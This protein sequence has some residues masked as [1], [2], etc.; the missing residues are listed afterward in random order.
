MGL[1][2]FHSCKE[3]GALATTNLSAFGVAA[4]EPSDGAPPRHFF[5]T[6]GAPP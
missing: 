2:L 6:A 1:C 3:V 4:S 5:H